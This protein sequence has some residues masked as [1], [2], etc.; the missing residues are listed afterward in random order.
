MNGKDLVKIALAVAIVYFSFR[1]IKPYMDNYFFEK[2]LDSAAQYGTIHSEADTRKKLTSIMVE[3]DMIGT[4]GDDIDLIIDEHKTVSIRFDYSDNI[5]VF[6][7]KV[8]EIN[9]SIFVVAKKVNN[10]II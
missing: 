2:A 3:H 7:K 9:F 4:T 10:P 8:H 6:G 5:K 1:G